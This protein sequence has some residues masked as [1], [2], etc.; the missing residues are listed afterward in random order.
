MLEG[1]LRHFQGT[2]GLTQSVHDFKKI[3]IY[4]EH[5]QTQ[6]KF[7]YRIQLKLDV[8]FR[9]PILLLFRRFSTVFLIKFEIYETIAR[10]FS[11][12]CFKFSTAKIHSPLVSRYELSRWIS[13]RQ[14]AFSSEPAATYKHQKRGKFWRQTHTPLWDLIGRIIFF[15]HAKKPSFATLI[16]Q[17]SCAYENLRRSFSVS[18]P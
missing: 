4:S 5:R 12:F 6:I 16:S 15:S 18:I 7:R 9:F 14:L 17:N 11:R 8:S 10:K 3:A 2:S 13:A 1:I